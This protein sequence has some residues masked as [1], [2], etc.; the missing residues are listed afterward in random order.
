MSK[1][2]NWRTELRKI[3]QKN[4]PQRQDSLFDQMRDL[5]TIANTFGFNDA[6]DY[7]RNKFLNDKQDE[8]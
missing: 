8:N 5:H 3:N 4:C 2:K 7:I 6:A 1:N